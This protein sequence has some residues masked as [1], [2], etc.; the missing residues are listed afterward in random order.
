MNIELSTLD[1]TKLCEP[2]E[3]LTFDLNRPLSRVDDL[4]DFYKQ[5]FQCTVRACD[6]G[7]AHAVVYWFDMD[8]TQ[9]IKISTLDKRYCFKQSA[10]MLEKPIELSVDSS[11]NISVTCQ[12]SCIGMWVSLP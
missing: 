3:L 8:L 7:L 11:I 4:L 5:S 12:E 1:Y 6:K 2:V 9:N 10:V